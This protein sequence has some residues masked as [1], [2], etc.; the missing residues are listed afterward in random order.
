MAPLIDLTDTIIKYT[1]SL[2]GE[3]GRKMIYEKKV[4]PVPQE[5][6]TAGLKQKTMPNKRLEQPSIL[7]EQNAQRIWTTNISHGEFPIVSS[8]PTSTIKYPRNLVGRENSATIVQLIEVKK[9]GLRLLIQ[10]DDK[11]GPMHFNKQDTTKTTLKPSITRSTI[12]FHKNMRLE[13]NLAH[14]FFAD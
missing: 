2:V 11:T 3:F 4:P 5:H 10:T 1:R 12:L 7:N 9:S 14:R 6:Q 8:T 13:I